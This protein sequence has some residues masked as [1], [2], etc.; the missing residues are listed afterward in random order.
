MDIPFEEDLLGPG[1]YDIRTWLRY[2]EAKRLECLEKDDDDWTLLDPVEWLYERAVKVLPGS[3]KLWYGY[4]QYRLGKQQPSRLHLLY[5]KNVFERATL[6]LP[7]MPRLWLEYIRFVGSLLRDINGLKSVVDASLRALPITQ[8]VRI[9]DEIVDSQLP[10]HILQKNW[11]QRQ[12]QL[13]P[14]RRKK[15]IKF[16]KRQGD[17]NGVV[18]QLMQELSSQSNTSLSF[19]DSEDPEDPEEK[20]S[21]SNWIELCNV[22]LEH[23][24]DV[25]SFD[26]PELFRHALAINRRHQGRFW[27]AFATYHL[28]RGEVAVARGIFEEALSKVW[29]VRDFAQVYDAYARMEETIVEVRLEKLMKKKKREIPNGLLNDLSNLLKR[30]PLLLNDVLLRQNPHSVSDWLSR[31]ALSADPIACLKE[32]ISV[33]N[34]SKA[35]GTFPQLIIA[36]A[37]ALPTPEE[38]SLLYSNTIRDNT[39]LAL[40]DLATLIISYSEHLKHTGVSDYL[41]PVYAG[42]ADKKLSKSLP[43]WNYL[44]DEE[45]ARGATG[46]TQAAYDRLLSL[47]LAQPQHIINYALFCEQVLEDAEAAFKIYERGIGM[48]GYPVAFEIWNIYLPKFVAKNGGKV[49]RT[50]DLFETALKDCPPQFISS[51][52]LLYVKFEE[53]YGVSARNALAV[54]KRICVA[55]EPSERASLFTLLLERVAQCSGLLAT[56]E[57]YEEAIKTVPVAQSIDFAL[58]YAAMEEQLGEVGR[59]RALYLHMAPQCDLRVFPVF[60]ERWGEFEA[61]CGDEQTFREMLRVKRSVQSVF[62]ER[63]PFIKARAEGVEPEERDEVNGDVVNEEEIQLDL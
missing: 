29:L 7:R 56:R 19:E 27:T 28:R 63:Q 42:L 43:L 4:L 1:Q 24:E 46:A 48:F 10:L 26:V 35:I 31:A 54:L 62:L 60:W 22:L 12:L 23:P 39:L 16:L 25:K 55:A 52:G 14:E 50:R 32:A 44:L 13:L 18:E 53:E 17:W 5:T 59:A 3:F 51:I 15:F 34:P 47:K 8:H 2:I 38:A 37:K 57:I 11:Q 33:V 40:E 9:W 58:K 30:H 20:E 45:E 61:R 49:E 36:L 21:T 41:D 6:A